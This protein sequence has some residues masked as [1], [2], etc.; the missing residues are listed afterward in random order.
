MSDVS[1]DTMTAT[2]PR[3][4]RRLSDKILI[5]FHLACDQADFEVAASLTGWI[6]WSGKVRSS[7]LRSGEFAAAVELH[8]QRAG[9]GV[10]PHHRPL[11]QRSCRLNR[12]GTLG[13]RIAENGSIRT[14]VQRSDSGEAVAAG[15]FG[16]RLGVA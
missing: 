5:A 3:Y 16:D 14:R 9:A 1:D 10:R 15:E 13:A 7:W 11:C 4:T 6:V 2:A 12:I 8:R